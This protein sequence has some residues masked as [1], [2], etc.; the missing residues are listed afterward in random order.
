MLKETELAW[1]SD[2]KEATGS[3][4]GIGLAAETPVPHFADL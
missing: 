2:L 4:G 1:G 3:D